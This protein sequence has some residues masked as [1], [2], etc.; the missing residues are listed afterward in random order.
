MCVHRGAPGRRA[1]ASI[2]NGDV[3]DPTSAEPAPTCYRHPERAT[4]IRCQRCGRA[5][6]PECQHQAAVGVQCPECVRGAQ[7]PAQRRASGWRAA[8]SPRRAVV[9]YVLMGVIAVVYAAQWLS[10]QALTQAWVLNPSL[11]GAEPWRL[12]TS[13][14]LHS[15][16][17]FVHV[18]FNLYALFAFGPLLESF[19]GKARFLALYLISGL[20]GSFAVVAIWEL[21]ILTGGAIET[22]TNGFL[23]PALALGASGAVFG[24]LGAYLPLR[25]AIGAN[26]RVLL[27]VLAV[28]VVLGFV[29]PNIAWEAHLGGL[30]VGAAIAAIYLRTRRPEQQRAQILGVAGIAAG[31]LLLIAVF[32]ATAPALYGL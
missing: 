13:T 19:L 29:V 18:L 30:A 24:L 9:T 10:G 27:I 11:V 28:N 31:I 14:F 5:V 21:W 1:G 22:A 3:S 26:I 2:Q 25:K 15:P 23:S 32:V 16:A 4:Y 6:C 7:T 8:L 12:L 20:G 17:S